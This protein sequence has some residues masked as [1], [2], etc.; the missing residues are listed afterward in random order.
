MR[1]TA[2]QWRMMISAN[3]NK[4]MFPSSQP[5]FANAHVMLASL[6]LLNSRVSR[7]GIYS[8]TFIDDLCRFAN[9]HAMLASLRLLNSLM[10]RS[11]IYR[12]TSMAYWQGFAN[13]HVVLASLQHLNWRVRFLAEA[14][15][16]GGGCEG[17]CRE[18]L[19]RGWRV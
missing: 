17:V 9:A 8:M 10:C 5:R 3:M 14:C 6:R 2:R 15:C 11:C 19:L 4:S 18:G 1:K 12:M 16:M 13:A 7:S